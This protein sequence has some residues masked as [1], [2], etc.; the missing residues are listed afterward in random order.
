MQTIYSYACRVLSLLICGLLIAPGTGEAANLTDV[1]GGDSACTILL[2]GEIVAGDLERFHERF[3]YPMEDGSLEGEEWDAQV[4]CL[5]S[6]GGAYRVGLD[7][8][9]YMSTL[10]ISIQTRVESE[11]YCASA[12]TF[13]FLAGRS[14]EDGESLQTSFDRAIEPGG[15][16]GFHAAS[17]NLPDDQT[18]ESSVVSEAYGLAVQGA[19]RAYE[20]AQAQDT[21]LFGRIEVF[22]PPYIVSRFLGT[23]P[24]DLYQIDTVGDA[25]LSGIPAYNY[26]AL[27]RLDGPLIRTICNNAYMMREK[28]FG[29]GIYS[30][31]K[32]DR[33]QDAKSLVTKFKRLPFVL[34][35]GIERTQSDGSV[36][37]RPFKNHINRSRQGTIVGYATGYPDSYIGEAICFVEIETDA[38]PGDLVNF[39]DIMG[40]S[41]GAGYD[42]NMA[43]PVRIAV[44]YDYVL[45]NSFSEV[46][47]NATVNDFEPLATPRTPLIFY[48]FDMALSA[49]PKIREAQPTVPQVTRADKDLSCDELWYERNAIM[50]R[51]GYCFGSARGLSTFGNDGCF[52]KSPVLNEAEK[53]NVGALRA[54]EKSL[55]C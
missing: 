39:G 20:L 34:A 13:I 16:L 22:A 46:L 21:G 15:L 51:N 27:A 18:Y 30:R 37:F 5:H 8:A 3:G 35:E 38:L 47:K 10:T 12:C 7:I 26:A 42:F 31:W 40:P 24:E 29:D 11:A 45:E 19:Q 2:E 28:G 44:L 36:V 43:S 23:P 33:N 14:V 41:T 55:G 48:P 6:P 25:L 54:T 17:L 50:H 53:A 49:L 1:T 4:L 52:T 32:T 9:E